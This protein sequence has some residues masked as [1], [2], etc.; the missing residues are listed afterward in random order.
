MKILVTGAAGF[1]GSAITLNL[2]RE[3]HEVV[4]LDSFSPYYSTELKLERKKELIESREIRFERL[5][6]SNKELVDNFF[7]TETFFNP[8]HVIS[9]TSRCGFADSIKIAFA[10]LLY[11][12]LVGDTAKYADVTGSVNNVLPQRFTDGV[13][14]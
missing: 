9:W 10:A 8:S 7:A 1:I 14:L 12:V 5:D 3:G 11:S 6:L 4:G 2:H 13:F